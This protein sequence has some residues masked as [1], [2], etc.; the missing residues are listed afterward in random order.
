MSANDRRAAREQ[1]LKVFNKLA[2]EHQLQPAAMRASNTRVE[3]LYKQ[4]CQ[5]VRQEQAKQLSDAREA[6]CSHGGTDLG[7]A[8]LPVPPGGQQ[9]MQDEPVDATEVLDQHRT[10]TS[11]K[12]FRLCSK[13]FM[14]TF[15]S[16]LFTA[17]FETWCA[18]VAWAYSNNTFA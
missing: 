12:D 4:L 13:A 11:K 2:D 10:L 3:E 18:F 8:L 9:Q 1:A 17:S 14:L 7:A 6:F 5:K 16:I 15:N